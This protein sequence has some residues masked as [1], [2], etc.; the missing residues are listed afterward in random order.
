M[1][2][3]ADKDVAARYGARVGR[4]ITSID[5]ASMPW[6]LDSIMGW[7]DGDWGIESWEW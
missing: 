2:W 7:G 1:K 3:A 6:Y 5:V 4:L